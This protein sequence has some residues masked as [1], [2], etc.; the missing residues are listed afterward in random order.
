MRSKERNATCSGLYSFTPVLAADEAGT[1]AEF[2]Q[3]VAEIGIAKRKRIVYEPVRSGELRHPGFWN[4]IQVDGRLLIGR[5]DEAI[6]EQFEPEG[7]PV[8]V[9]GYHQCRRPVWNVHLDL[10]AAGRMAVHHLW[11]LGHRRMALLCQAGSYDYQTEFRHG[12]EDAL[13][14]KGLRPGDYEIITPETDDVDP[15]AESLRRPSRPTAVVAVEGGRVSRLREQA[16]EFGLRVPE[17]LSLALFGRPGLSDPN[18]THVDPAPEEIGRRGMDLLV[19]LAEGAAEPP[20]RVLIRPSLRE[21]NTCRRL[22][23]CP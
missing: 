15:L 2:L 3:G 12:F 19:R 21:G 9:L 20:S 6:L 17:D 16:R 22:E 1:Y 5:V 7:V 8:V 18:L 11:E 23:H 4:S 10:A 13:Q 14:G